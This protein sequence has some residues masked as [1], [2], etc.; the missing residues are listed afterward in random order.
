[1]VRGAIEHVR[2]TEGRDLEYFTRYEHRHVIG[3][4]VDPHSPGHGL[5]T[6]D[7]THSSQRGG[8]SHYGTIDDILRRECLPAMAAGKPPRPEQEKLKAAEAEERMKE[9]QKQMA[10]MSRLLKSNAGGGS[11]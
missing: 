3:H 9:M 11:G 8:E 2:R 5:K 6:V 10:E 4:H 7:L 1:C